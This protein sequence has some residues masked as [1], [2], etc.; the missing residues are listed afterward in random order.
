MFA[1]PPN[2]FIQPLESRTFLSGAPMF[3]DP[4]GA[5]DLLSSSSLHVAPRSAALKTPVNVIGTFIGTLTTK[6]ATQALKVEVITEPP[7]GTI[8]GNIT[9]GEGT[10]AVTTPFTGTVRGHAVRIEYASQGSTVK[11]K[12]KVDKTDSTIMG[13]FSGLPT[14]TKKKAKGKFTVTRVA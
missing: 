5:G 8:T 13:T 9:L 7:D 3:V 12:G 2:R 10:S 6:T 14:G 11:V 4:V 1:C